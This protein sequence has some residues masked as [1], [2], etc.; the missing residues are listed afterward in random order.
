MPDE[1][2]YIKTKLSDWRHPEVTSNYGSTE[3][4]FE[5]MYKSL[6]DMSKAVQ[7]AVASSRKQYGHY[8]GSYSCIVDGK[9]VV[10][11]ITDNADKFLLEVD[12]EDMTISWSIQYDPF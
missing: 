8:R 9:T 10:F 7:D 12:W 3:R 5:L 2:V 11:D 4:I 1:Y 6:G